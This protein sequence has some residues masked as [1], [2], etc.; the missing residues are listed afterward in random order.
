MI[1]INDAVGADP[2]LLDDI[3]VHPRDLAI[4]QELLDLDLG[5]LVLMKRRRSGSRSRGFSRSPLP[6]KPP[7]PPPLP[8]P[9]SR[10][11][12]SASPKPP[13][14]QISVAAT[15]YQAPVMPPYGDVNMAYNAYGHYGYMTMPVQS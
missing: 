3:L 1:D 11:S 8:A 9:S 4:K 7:S 12:T 10:S 6:F 5:L 13:P 2:S 14:S 15:F